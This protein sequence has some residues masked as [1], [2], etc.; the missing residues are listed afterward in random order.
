MTSQR[1]GEPDGRAARRSACSHSARIG[2][3]II[4][5]NGLK[6]SG[7]MAEARRLL[8]DTV[9]A[10]LR[11]LDAHA[12]LGHLVFDHDPGKALLHY[13]IG[14][15]IGDLSL[16]PDFDGVLPRGMIDNRPFLRCVHGYGQTPWRLRQTGAARVVFTRLLWMNPGD[17][18]GIRFL[19]PDR[20]A[21][22][23]W[24]ERTCR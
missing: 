22:L 12:H 13:K 23:S 20:D 19:L 7:Q 18:Q 6:H 2:D 17:N 5:S 1:R 14:V 16:G 9:S 24:E 10:D 8:H 11:C 21:G 3:P 4:E 15:R